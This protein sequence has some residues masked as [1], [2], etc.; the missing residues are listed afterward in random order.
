M[1]TKI[2]YGLLITLVFTVLYFGLLQRYYSSKKVSLNTVKKPLT[3][4]D[5]S[6]KTK[7]IL[8]TAQIV[9]TAVDI[10]GKTLWT[11]DPRKDGNI[12]PYRI[13]RPVIVYF[14]LG[15][16]KHNSNKEVIHIAYNNSQFG[17]IDKSTG[18]F[19]SYGQD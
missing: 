7:F 8:D 14:K 5:D 17:V 2:K 19:T 1:K 12:E 13:A 16:D 15:F 6:T 18:R 11:T 3:L 10:N 4:I 9:I